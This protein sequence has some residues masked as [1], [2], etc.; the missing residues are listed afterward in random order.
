MNNTK[1]CWREISAILLRWKAIGYRETSY[2]AKLIGHVP[3]V[4]PQAY[5]HTVYAPLDQGQIDDM[6]R[7]LQAS[8]SSDFRDFLSFSNGLNCFSD[9]L[10]IWGL[11]KDYVRQ[12]D[13][14]WQ[15]YDL[16]DMNHPG[17]RP[18]NRGKSIVLIGGYNSD[19]SKLYFDDS[20]KSGL[21]YRCSR[22]SIT[23]LNAWPNF[24]TMLDQEVMRLSF[25]YSGIGIKLDSDQVTTPKDHT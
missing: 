1:D 10:S 8:F 11:R 2:G 7:R 21:V 23:P 15:P 19:G 20:N 3:S 25:L 5:L 22:D 9:A 13:A 12:G 17:E 14:V 4:A 24:W 6:E 16:I 18:R